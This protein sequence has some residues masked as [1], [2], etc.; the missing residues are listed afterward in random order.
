MNQQPQRGCGS[1]PRVGPPRAYPGNARAAETTPTGLRLKAQGWPAPGL[2]WEHARCRDNPNGV[3]AS[4]PRCRNPVGVVDPSP[5][6]P[7]VA[8][9]RAA[10][11]GFEPQPR[12]GR[13]LGLGPPPIVSVPR[14]FASN[15]PVNCRKN[16]AHLS[17]FSLVRTVSAIYLM[18]T[19]CR[20]L[21][22]DL[23]R[24]IHGSTKVAT[25]VATKE[26]L[27]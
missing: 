10:P 8:T 20:R 12:W 6:R 7:R 22:R 11:L 27:L 13:S 17:S 3:V 2:P 26:R 5:R 25:K 16:S 23:R 9:L 21:C 14:N 18:L 19:L 1:K 24:R 4:A 15:R